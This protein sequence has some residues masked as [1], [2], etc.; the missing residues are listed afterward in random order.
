MAG[1]FKTLDPVTDKTTTRTLLHEAIPLTGSIISG[2]YGNSKATEE[3]IKN[4][5]HGMFQS[6]YDYPYLSSSANHI[7][8]VTVGYSANSGLSA[9]TNVQNQKKINIY[10]EMA[11]LLMGYSSSGEI[12]EFDEDGNLAAGGTKMK[13][14]I[15]L[16]FSRLLVK[17]EIKKG[18]FNLELGVSGAVN[19]STHHRRVKLYDKGAATNFL[20]NSPA[21]EYG[22]LYADSTS[23]TNLVTDDA[24][25]KAGLIFYQAGIAVVTGAIFVSAS[26]GGG[27]LK[28]SFAD[29]SGTGRRLTMSIGNNQTITGYPGR[30]TAKIMGEAYQAML[31]GSEISGAANAIRH[32]IYN[33]EF[34][35]TT[36][37]NS[38]IYYC[39]VNHGDYNY[40]TN[41][42]YTS[43]SKIV[44]KDN[45]T[46]QPV[47]YITAV[48]L[49]SADNELLAVAKLSEPLKKDPSTEFTI[50]VRLDY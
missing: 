21:G 43:G 6:V 37:I 15:F 7:F 27:L 29:T 2:T 12:L 26:Y 16:N 35:N 38:T 4:F 25:Q 47:S 41:P 18:T 24:T 39:R 14:C 13:S 1:T 40:S 3:N 11:Q 10:N 20:I 17:D 50:R 42:T 8:D 23:G 36:E 31:T 46:D 28:N 19:A 48:G 5:A 32:R 44:V 45:S 33:V 30:S 34:Q 49:Y 9:S 22:I